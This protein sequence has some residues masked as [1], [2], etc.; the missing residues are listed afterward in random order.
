VVAR[1]VAWSDDRPSRWVYHHILASRWFRSGDKFVYASSKGAVISITKGAGLGAGAA[2]AS[3][4]R[5]PR[6]PVTC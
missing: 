5:H 1:A 3:G 6:P 2:R 4:E